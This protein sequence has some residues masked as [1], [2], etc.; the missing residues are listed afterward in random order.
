VL[1]GETGW[2]VDHR[3]DFTTALVDAIE[4]LEDRGR[5]ETMATTCRT[6]AGCF[7]WDRSAE[8]LAGVVLEEMRFAAAKRQGQTPNRRSARS[9]MAVLAGFPA[10]DAAA[11]RSALRAT[12]EVVEDGNGAAVVLTGCDEFTAAGVLARIGV[13]DGSFRLVDRRLL[14]G[15]PGAPR[16]VAAGAAENKARSA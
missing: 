16:T 12:D 15:G 3:D 13:R 6:W 2:L 5:A 7:S 10:A 14:L 8:L 9:D 1:H 11:V 4:H